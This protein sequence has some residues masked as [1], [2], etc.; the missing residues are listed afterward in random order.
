MRTVEPA[1]DYEGEE[2][3]LDTWKITTLTGEVVRI[4][5][6]AKNNVDF[7]VEFENGAV[8]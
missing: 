5:T 6:L 8:L 1:V 3:G 7:D 4:V 2:H